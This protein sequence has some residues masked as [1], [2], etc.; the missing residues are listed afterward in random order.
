MEK[1][2]AQIEAMKSGKK[3]DAKPE[4]KKDEVKKDEP[5][6]SK[7]E[8]EMEK[9]KAQIEAMKSGKK[10]DTKSEEKKDE[11]K[12]EEK[13]SGG[14]FGFGKKKEEE[15]KS[16]PKSEPKTDE[17]KLESV[18]KDEPA[19]S[20]EKKD[21]P[22]KS[23]D[24]KDEVKKDEASK[25]EDKKDE[26]KSEDKKPEVK[27][28]AAVKPGAP[29][30]VKKKPKNA[31]MARL[32]AE[33]EARKAAQK[34]KNQI[35]LIIYGFCGLM[36]VLVLGFGVWIL[37]RHKGEKKP[38]QSIQAPR[39]ELTIDSSG[40]KTLAPAAS[41]VDVPEVVGP[42]E[43]TDF[44]KD[45]KKRYDVINSWSNRKNQITAVGK[46]ASDMMEAFQKR[47]DFCD[48]YLKKF[49]YYDEFYI[50]GESSSDDSSYGS[51]YGS[52]YGSD[53]GS[54]GEQ[55]P[56]KPAAEKKKSGKPQVDERTEAMYRKWYKDVQRA[57][58]KNNAEKMKYTDM[59]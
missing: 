30:A 50:D 8:L 19:K 26:A 58:D 57:R 21:E 25:S 29:G 42:R 10:A 51:S 47:V 59:D 7:A 43:L 13:K 45:M 44:E 36:T 54:E 27:S 52:D 34:K 20:E 35:N 32:M 15:K 9:I 22:A 28:A 33:E 16:E 53:Y 12:K 5:K 55:K 11:P 40:A 23:E 38:Q 39:G 17:K 18:K 6:K 37:T 31:A 49:R 1:I 56:E 48:A 3:A 24:K 41:T 2:K 46:S 4:E 14:L